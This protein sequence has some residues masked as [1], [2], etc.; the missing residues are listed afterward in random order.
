MRIGEGWD[1]NVTHSQ[2]YC[3]SALIFNQGTVCLV[4]PKKAIDLI[5]LKIVENADFKCKEKDFSKRLKQ[6]E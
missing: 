6:K 1:Y 4:L 3:D 5:C 2:F